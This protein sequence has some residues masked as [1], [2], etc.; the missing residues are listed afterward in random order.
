MP[1][2][3]D[4]G[5]VN[6]ARKRPRNRRSRATLLVDARSRR[7]LKPSHFT[8][9]AVAVVTMAIVVLVGWLAIRAASASLF[10]RNPI[11]TI[12][13]LD[14]DSDDHVA[15]DYIRRSRGIRLG[16]NLF[17]FDIQAVRQG[18]LR[19]APHYR[20]MEITRILPDTLHISLVPRQP[21]ARIVQ[22][23]GYVYAVDA[24][25]RVFKDRDED[26]VLPVIQGYEEVP[27]N[28]G[29]R[30]ESLAA[31]AV[32]VLVAL[33]ETDLHHDVAI[34]GI[35][36]GK[37]VPGR[38]DALRLYLKNELI[39]DLWWR[40]TQSNDTDDDLRAR[41]AYLQAMLKREKARGRDLKIV[42]LTADDFTRN[43]AEYWN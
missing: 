11:Y 14:I 26:L 24:E 34:R 40:R 13:N 16:G 36:V 32:N 9:L 43:A 41:L 25:S 6:R 18:F 2:G 27:L 7:R 23:A 38:E 4:W 29:D 19:A 15:L 10:S 5:I 28:P 3:E 17:E 12:A 33:S 30:V 37:R 31:D 35:H 39:V 8:H 1:F 22:R 21:I 20:T 42:N